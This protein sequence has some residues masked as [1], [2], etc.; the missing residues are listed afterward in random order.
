MSGAREAISY[1]LQNA[2]PYR[3]TANWNT[4]SE[5]LEQY[6]PLAFGG[7]QTGPQVLDT[8]QSLASE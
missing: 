2:R 3:T 5:L 1:A 7:S 8:V 6:V 4:V